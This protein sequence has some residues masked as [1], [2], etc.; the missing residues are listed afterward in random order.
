MRRRSKRLRI[1]VLVIV[2]IIIAALAGTYVLSITTNMQGSNAYG[3]EDISGGG[4]MMPVDANGNPIVD[5]PPDASADAPVDTTPKLPSLNITTPT[6]PAMDVGKTI[7]LTYEL[8]NAP[9]GT[10][11]VWSSTDSSVATVDTSGTVTAV[12]PG[13]AWI[14]VAAGG[15]KAD[16]PIT[17]NEQPVQSVTILIAELDTS[18]GQA[19]YDIKVGDILHLS[20][21]VQPKGAKFSGGYKWS[22]PSDPDVAA[23]DSSTREL[24]A[25]KAGDTQMTVTAGDKS[26][27]VA[28]HITANENPLLAYIQNMLPYILIVVAAIV[29][30][31]IIIAALRREQ[32]ARRREASQRRK[33]QREQAERAQA[34]RIAAAAAAQATA[35]AGA[36]NSYGQENGDTPP[37]GQGVGT[38]TP[39]DSR[40]TI[41]YGSGVGAAQQSRNSDTIRLKEEEERPLSL[42]DID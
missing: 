17:V 12:A 15:L 3:T 20:A 1:L 7:D 23:F 41:V 14:A 24:T 28:F 6:P 39:S 36:Q 34:E 19:S 22:Q 11:V 16:V 13:T 27:T 8:L 38:P 5:T 33:T 31:L 21:Q 42:D 29:I 30:I 2:I 18:Q 25:T 4:G 40:E 10:K 32:R 26:A 37:G 9:A 35:Q